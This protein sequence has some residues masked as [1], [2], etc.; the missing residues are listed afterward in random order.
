MR[1]KTTGIDETIENFDKIAKGIVNAEKP[2]RQATTIVTRDA[3]LNAPVDTGRLRASI[4][5]SVRSSSFGTVGVV[6]SNVEYA[7]YQ[8]LGTQPFWPPVAALETW[9]R[10]HGMVAFLVAR[11]IAQRGIRAKRFLQK[12]YNSNVNRI[13]QLFNDYI[14][15]L[16]K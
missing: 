15:R 2:M 16:T 7:P 11:A 5:P 14:R 9:A 4:M 12:A 3:R 6:G 13:N 8:E 1:L 10:R